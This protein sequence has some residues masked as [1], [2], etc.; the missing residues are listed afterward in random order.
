M[1]ISSVGNAALLQ[2]MRQAMFSKADANG[3]GQL[4]SDEFQ[5]IGQDLQGG[6]KSGPPRAMR[7][8]GGFAANFASAMMGSLLS[9][10]EA[11][12][13]AEDIFTS[14]DADADGKLTAEEL[15]A[16]MAA[17]APPGWEGVDHTEMA[18]S[19]LTD[20][21]SDGDGAL[22]L[23]EFEA[24]RPSGPPPDGP[25]MTISFESAST[26]EVTEAAE[27]TT[28]DAAD[29]N[30]DGVV[31]MSELL[32]SLQSA[33]SQASGFS[34]EVSDLLRQLLDKLMSETDSTTEA[35]A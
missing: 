26:D 32:A 20:A 21:D 1:N 15:A 6:G 35:A 30:Q 2:E 17:H 12:P 29:T 4:S 34:T 9:M 8:E 13:S 10:Q 18:A 28:Y 19:L 22:T 14:A 27:E 7:G 11:P 5:S 33:E 25:R 23:E 31:S 16:D 3:D 24:A